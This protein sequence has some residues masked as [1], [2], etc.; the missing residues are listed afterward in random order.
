MIGVAEYYLDVAIFKLFVRYGLTVPCV[1][2]GMKTG[3]WTSPCAVVSLPSR[4]FVDLSFCIS[5]NIFYTLSAKRYT[6]N[7]QHR[8][9]V[10]E[11][12]VLFGYRLPVRLEY[13]FFAGEC[14]NQ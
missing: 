4:A 11:E 9:A 3:V 6:L 1:P 12:A 7:D 5:L 13:K 8:I 10:T 2:T 14:R